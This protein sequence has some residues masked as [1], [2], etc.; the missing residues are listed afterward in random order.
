ML[1]K[2]LKQ[3][4]WVDIVVIILLIRISYIALQS[5]LF[6][7]SF[8]LLGTILALYLSLHYYSVL[9]SFLANRMGIKTLSPLALNFISFIV[10]MI[11]GYLIFK[12]LRELFAKFIKLEPTAGL[13]KWGG[14][15]LGVIRGFLSVSLVIF[16]LAA[17][18]AGYFRK[19]VKGSFS[20][21]DL[22]NIS[23]STYAGIWN[24]ALSKFMAKENFNQNTG[25]IKKSLEGKNEI[26]N[27]L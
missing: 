22:I 1:F 14:L 13:D 2:M 20:G 23:I 26:R 8:K 11:A 16:M 3:L 6:L 10:L 21:K 15:I 17:S 4:N 7:E 9:G 18:H 25:E 19:S 12:I 27:S 24:A 5:G